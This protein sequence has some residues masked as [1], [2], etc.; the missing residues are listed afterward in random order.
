MKHK[1]EAGNRN[2]R[3]ERTMLSMINSYFGLCKSEKRAL[4]NSL[5]IKTKKLGISIRAYLEKNYENIC[6]LPKSHK[7][8][9]IR[10]DMLPGWKGYKINRYLKKI[11]VFV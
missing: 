6:R 1:R 3:S 9:I 10:G 5:T 7:K 8:S 11:P 4:H 2:K